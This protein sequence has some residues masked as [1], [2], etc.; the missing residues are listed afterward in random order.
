[1]LRTFFIRQLIVTISCF[2]FLSPLRG[3]DAREIL[4]H[5]LDTVSNGDISKWDGVKTTYA[6][7]VNYFSTEDFKSGFHPPN[8]DKVSYGR[9][10]KVWPDKV[11]VEL[12]SDSLFL[13]ST[14]N[15]YFFKNKRVIVLG[16]MPPMELNNDD[17][18]T[19]TLDFYPTLVK[20]SMDDSRKITYNGTKLISGLE[21]PLHEIDIETRQREHKFF[22]INT[23]TYLLEAIYDPE[24]NIYTI[25]SNYKNID[26]YLIPMYTA[27]MN[28]GVIFAWEIYKKVIFNQPIDMDKFNYPR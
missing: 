7:A 4:N 24:T 28:D 18:M 12:Y 27:S 5:Y 20:K 15:F 16:N 23:H 22:L 11:K 6:T 13:N 19:M 3:Q 2:F 1:M 14:S 26:G 10:Y 17:T 21:Y 25:I 9:I 8:Y